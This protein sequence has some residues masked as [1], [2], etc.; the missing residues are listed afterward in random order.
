MSHELNVLHHPDRCRF[1]LS[2]GLYINAGLPPGEE[3][4][5]EGNYWCAKTQ[6]VMGPD[7]QLCD[8]EFCLNRDRGCHEALA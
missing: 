1:L 2:K 3:V 4:T 7:R 6:T 5:G 8:P